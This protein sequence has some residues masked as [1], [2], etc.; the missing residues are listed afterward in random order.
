[1]DENLKMAQAAINE[2]LRKTLSTLPENSVGNS[3]RLILT[4]RIERINEDLKSLSEVSL[5][6]PPRPEEPKPEES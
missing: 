6:P 5:T 2:I 1:M 4:E 3:L